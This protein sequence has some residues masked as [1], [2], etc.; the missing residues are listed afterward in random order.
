[1]LGIF[2]SDTIKVTI[3]IIHKDDNIE[4]ID[5]TG[6]NYIMFAHNI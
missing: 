2:K 6:L 4:V 5:S 3:Q 1:M